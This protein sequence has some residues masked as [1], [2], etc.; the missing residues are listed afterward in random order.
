MAR[1]FLNK[2]NIPGANSYSD[3]N[4]RIEFA[5]FGDWDKTIKTLQKLSPEIKKASIKAQKKVCEL[6]LKKVKGHLRSQDLNW[7]PLHPDYAERKAI[8]GL[9]YRTLMAYGN[10]YRSIEVWTK[11]SQHMVF[12]GVKKGIYTRKLNGGRSRLE[13]AQIAAIHEFSSGRKIPKRP[14]WNPTIAEIGGAKGIKKLYVGSL[15]HHLRIAGIPVKQFQNI[16]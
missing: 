16:F 7:A 12:V 1:T 10:Y 9:S 5:L 6:I 8:G 14:L 11:G 15:V 3:F 13:V 4:S 2:N